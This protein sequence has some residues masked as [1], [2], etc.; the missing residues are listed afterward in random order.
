MWVKPP[1]TRCTTFWRPGEVTGVNSKFNIEVDCVLRHICDIRKRWAHKGLNDDFVTIPGSVQINPVADFSE[2]QCDASMDNA[3]LMPNCDA[4]NDPVPA[5]AE[6]RT[7]RQ[8]RLPTRYDDFF[9]NDDLSI[10]E[11]RD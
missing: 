8:R 9:V 6:R 11:E 4:A 5:D 2:K 1:E 7:S 10:T 3:G